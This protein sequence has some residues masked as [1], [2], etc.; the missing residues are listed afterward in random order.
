MCT[1]LHRGFK[2][3]PDAGRGTNLIHVIA[4]PITKPSP[5]DDAPD[6]STCRRVVIDSGRAER[7]TAR[8]FINRL[9]GGKRHEHA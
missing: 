7:D 9:L 4:G 1:H 8:Q 5:D 6:G 2:P 3:R